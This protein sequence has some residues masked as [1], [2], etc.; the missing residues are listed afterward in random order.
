MKDPVSENKVACQ[1][2]DEDAKCPALALT[3]HVYAHAHPNI[4]TQSYKYT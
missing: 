4:Q 1:E 2:I 3:K